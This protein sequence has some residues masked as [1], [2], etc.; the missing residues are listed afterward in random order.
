M[1]DSAATKIAAEWSTRGRYILND[2]PRPGEVPTSM[3]PPLSLTMLAQV[4][5]PSPVPFPVSF[6]VKNGSKMHSLISGSSQSRYH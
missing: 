3:R 1:V 2:V 4:A 6:V 5:S